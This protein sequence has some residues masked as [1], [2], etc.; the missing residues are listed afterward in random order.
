MKLFS[1][2]QL[3]SL[4][5]IGDFSNFRKLS[6]LRYLNDSEEMVSSVAILGPANEKL[7]GDNSWTI[8]K[9]GAKS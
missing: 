5:A 3:T 6:N 8:L 9:E 7:A 1:I 4:S 2:F